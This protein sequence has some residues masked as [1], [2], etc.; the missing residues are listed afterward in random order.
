MKIKTNSKIY[1]N[2][3]ISKIPFEKF[4]VLF[5][6]IKILFEAILKYKTPH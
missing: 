6:R 4:K 5:F 2:L 3:K 1:P